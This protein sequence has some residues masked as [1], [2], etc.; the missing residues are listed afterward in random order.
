MS[1]LNVSVVGNLTADPELR[2]TAAGVPVAGMR[3]IVNHRRYNKDAR[4]WE[5]AGAS[6]VDVTAWK[7]LGENAA[8]SLRKGQEII[9]SGPAVLRT[10]QRRDGS[11]GTALEVTADSIG[12]NL[13]WA[14]LDGRGA[15]PDPWGGAPQGGG[16]ALASPQGSE[17]D[18]PF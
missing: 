6:A 3:V 17:G 11:E 12:P 14:P 13:R 5:D 9:V 15:T 16:Q 7:Q 4:E 8:K 2:Y 18:P 1:Q 10:F